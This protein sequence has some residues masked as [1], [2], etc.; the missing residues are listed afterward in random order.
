MNLP[1]GQRQAPEHNTDADRRFRPILWITLV[2]YV[3]SGV[4][5]GLVRVE[6]PKEMDITELPPRMAKLIIPKKAVEEKPKEPEKPEEVEPEPEEPEP[7]KEEAPE[8]EVAPPTADS[9]RSGG[10]AK[11]RGHEGGDEYGSS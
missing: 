1:T 2:I 3:L 9:R 5:V 7:V 11:K 4:V 8:E 10:S 6:P